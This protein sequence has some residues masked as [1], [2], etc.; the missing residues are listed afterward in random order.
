MKTMKIHLRDDIE[1]IPRAVRAPRLIPVHQ[2]AEAAKTIEELI[3]KGVIKGQSQPTGAIRHFL[4]K[5][6]MEKCAL[7]LILY[8]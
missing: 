7:S 5:K 6:I 3:K 1:V 8:N 4:L 2:E